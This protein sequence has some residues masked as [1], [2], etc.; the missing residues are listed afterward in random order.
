MNSILFS[1]LQ[2]SYT[3]VIYYLWR[4]TTSEIVAPY[5][6][7]YMDYNLVYLLFPRWY[8]FILFAFTYLPYY[9]FNFLCLARREACQTSWNVEDQEFCVLCAGLT[10]NFLGFISY[11]FDKPWFFTERNFLMCYIIPST[12][13]FPTVVNLHHQHAAITCM[14]W[15]KSGRHHHLWRPS[16]SRR[17]RCQQPHWVKTVTKWTSD[18]TRSDAR[19]QGDS[20]HQNTF[21]GRKRKH[22]G[23]LFPY[24]Y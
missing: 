19:H 22:D 5:T 1:Q 15:N 4:D 14:L 11:Q 2:F 18:F 12:W 20:P 8:V 6:S 13:G 3:I 10:S 21:L 16:Y 9:T 24:Y 17:R 7:F 23:V